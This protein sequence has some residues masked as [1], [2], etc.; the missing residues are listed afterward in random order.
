MRYWYF[1]ATLPGFLFG[2][3]PPFSEAEFLERCRHSLEPDDFDEIDS[4]RD[5]LLAPGEPSATR[6]AF[7]GQFMVWERAFRRQLALLRAQAAGK[8]VSR[9][10]TTP[11]SVGDPTQA[12]A[13]TDL[14]QTAVQAAADCFASA[15]PYQAE[16]AVEKERWSAAERFSTFA[17]FDI[18]FIAA[19][20]IK[21]NIVCRLA[22]LERAAGEAGYRRLYDEIL[23]GAPSAVETLSSGVQA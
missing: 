20:R 2:A 17:S 18:D 3:Q 10:L 19:Y 15:D 11:S 1:A 22:R 13:Q 21:L 4:C 6:S 5:R 14:I 12:L 9:Y 7:L 23:G 16:L 8:D